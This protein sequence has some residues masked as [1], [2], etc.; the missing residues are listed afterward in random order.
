MPRKSRKQSLSGEIAGFLTFFLHTAFGLLLL[1]ASL[2]AMVFVALIVITANNY[3]IVY[4]SFG[5][6]SMALIII[7]WLRYY[8]QDR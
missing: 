7:A 2:M 4:L 3:H 8:M 1:I 5:I 6:I